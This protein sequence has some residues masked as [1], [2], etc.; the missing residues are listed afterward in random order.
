[1]QKQKISRDELLEHYDNYVDNCTE[2]EI[3][4]SFKEWQREYSKDLELILGL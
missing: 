4:L 3:P 2:D 1:M